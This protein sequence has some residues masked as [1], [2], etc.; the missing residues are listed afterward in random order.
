MSESVFTGTS[1]RAIREVAQEGDLG[2]NS[3]E[4]VWLRVILRSASAIDPKQNYT[5]S[6]ALI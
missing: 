3:T 4:V 1:A 6:F 5:A 2:S